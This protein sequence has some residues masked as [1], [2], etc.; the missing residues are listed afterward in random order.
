[1]VTAWEACDNSVIAVDDY[2]VSFTIEKALVILLLRVAY[3]WFRR[4]F[5]FYF[6]F[7]FILWLY[8]KNEFERSLND[9]LDKSIIKSIV[10]LKKNAP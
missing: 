4:C 5:L 7:Y 3:F 10:H 9:V 2:L 8:K 6:I 1:M